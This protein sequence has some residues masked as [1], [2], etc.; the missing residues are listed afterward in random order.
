MSF[1]FDLYVTCSSWLHRV[2]PRVKLTFVALG[3]VAL[4]LFKNLWVMLAVLVVLHVLLFS[5]GVPRSRVG[6]VWR[7]MLPLNLLIPVMWVIF[8]PE[9]DLLLFRFW[10]LRV[11]A[12]GVVRGVALV[13]R[14]DAISFLWSTWLFTTDQATVVRSLVKL[15]LPYEW[16]LVLAMGLRY[17]PTFSGLFGVVRDA[18]QSRGLDLSEGRWL[19]RLR[20]HLPILVAMIISALRTAEKLG[21]ALEARALGLPGVRRTA[22]REIAF[23]P[24][25]YAFLA[26]VLATFAILALARLRFGFGA[27]PLYLF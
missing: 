17:I 6:W 18:Q 3:T 24:V 9:G 8:Y 25:D 12:L 14:L 19:A 21:M 1:G 22:F 15:G 10:F 5:A 2:D 26:L 13:L 20:A 16:G 23:R 4:L 7:A 11:T 27:H